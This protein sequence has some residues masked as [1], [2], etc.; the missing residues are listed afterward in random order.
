MLINIKLTLIYVPFINMFTKDP[1][2][3]DRISTKIAFNRYEKI[4]KQTIDDQWQDEI[5]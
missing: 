4:Q 1:Y 5:I 3:K 2:N